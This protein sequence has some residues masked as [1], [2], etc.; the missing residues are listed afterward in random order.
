MDTHLRGG[1]GHTHR[2]TLFPI[3]SIMPRDITRGLS[4]TIPVELVLEFDLVFP[5]FLFS[6]YQT[7]SQTPSQCYDLQC[8]E[9][10]SPVP[11]SHLITATEKQHS[12]KV[13]EGSGGS[14]SARETL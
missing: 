13:V 7:R 1:L 2:H 3:K 11:R 12:R 9:P 4:G 14:N 8:E 6:L 5:S 10:N